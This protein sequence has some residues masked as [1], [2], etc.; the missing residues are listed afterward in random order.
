MTP[1]RTGGGLS[2]AVS[3]AHGPPPCAPQ[4]LR[5]LLAIFPHLEL[6]RVGN[7][8]G[9][10]LFQTSFFAML[11]TSHNLRNLSLIRWILDIIP[12]IPDACDKI[13]LPLLSRLLLA[14]L[15]RHCTSLW[16]YLD[17]PGTALIEFRLDYI[18][19]GSDDEN[20]GTP[21]T[22]GLLYSNPTRLDFISTFIRHVHERLPYEIGG[23]SIVALVSDS[24]VDEYETDQAM[25][26]Y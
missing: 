3:E 10:L 14:G 6:T 21:K 13:E 26:I 5:A 2:Y 16:P 17:V 4:L 12:A 24:D 11:R 9:A 19:P 22:M 25:F 20:N 1:T 7:A 8:P 18:G 15:L 23:L